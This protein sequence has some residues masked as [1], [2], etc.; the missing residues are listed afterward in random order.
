MKQK[1]IGLCAIAASFAATS[2]AAEPAM[3]SGEPIKISAG[4]LRGKLAVGLSTKTVGVVNV[5]GKEPGIFTVATN[6]SP[7]PGLYLFEFLQRDPSGAPVFKNPIE[8]DQPNGKSKAPPEGTI[9]QTKDGLIHGL[10]VKNKQLVRTRFDAAEKKFVVSGEEIALTGLPRNPGWMT[11]VENEDGSLEVLLGVKDDT[12]QR[13]TETKTWRDP[14]YRPFDGAGVY[15]GG[16]PFCYLYSA[17]LENIDAPQFTQLRQVTPTQREALLHFGTITK[18]DLGA[19]RER[20]I[21]TGSWFGNFLYYH[22][23]SSD[24]VV[25]ENQ[26]LVSDGA[27]VA[28][29]HGAIR[30][31]PIAYPNAQTGKLSDLIVG[32][33]GAL[34]YYRFTGKFNKHGAPI[35]AEPT[36]VLEQNSK[37]YAGSLPVINTA[38]WDGDGDLDILAGNSEG[39]VIFFRNAGTNAKPSFE[40]SVEIHAAGKPI[41]IQ[42]GYNDVQGPQEARWGYASPAIADWNDDGL[43]DVVMSSATAKHKVFLNTGTPKE[44]KLEAA[45]PLYCRGLDLHGTWRVKPGVAKLDGR[46]AYFALDD[47]DE[48]HLYWQIDPYNLEDGGK[49]K[50]ED[51]T[52]IRANFLAAGGTGRAKFLPTDWDRDGKIDLLVGTPRHGSIPNP[53]K[54]LPQSAGLKGAAIIFLKNVGTNAQP[55]YAWPTMMQFKGKPIYLDQHECSA[56]VWDTGQPDGPDLLAGA[57]DGRVIYYA[58]KDLSWGPLE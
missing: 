4:V 26:R 56:A 42:P 3:V 37:M 21:L 46:M 39:K 36:P 24:S 49:L 6:H 25:L 18:V 15:R 29:R 28:I 45:V 14:A 10:W 23:T 58:R 16:W 33:E 5:G 54:G 44:P 19:G 50:L 35:Y 7:R 17:C 34:Y 27:G 48:F 13:P 53:E 1:L 22:N 52:N 8:I 55:V 41:H 11:V 47:D 20:D 43:L 31:S 2:F 38:D 32:G 9:F 30:P 40:D 57:Q 51:G 12:P